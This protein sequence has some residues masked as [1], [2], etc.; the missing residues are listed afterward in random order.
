MY[1]PP[2]C[3]YFCS[4][5]AAPPDA[6]AALEQLAYEFG[7]TYDAYLAT[8]SDRRYFWSPGRRGVVGF[9][10]CRGHALATGGL[11]AP[12]EEQAEL[13]DAFLEFTRRNRL[14]ALF[15]SLGRDDLAPYRERG[16]GVNKCSEELMLRLDQTHWTGK[17]Y[18]WVR[19]QE[20][21][22]LRQD[23]ALEEVEADPHDPEY[24][25]QLAPQLAE[26]S[27]QHVAQTLHA[28]ELEFFEGRFTPLEL[29][30]RRLFVA[31]QDAR[32]VAFVVCNPALG[33]DLWAI[34]IYRR[35]PDAPRGVIPFAM[36]QIMRR[37]KAEGVSYVSLSSVPFLRCGPPFGGDSKSA[38]F[39]CGFWWKR[40]N[41]LFDVRGLYHY[42]TRFR[43]AFRELYMAGYPRLTYRSMLAITDAWGVFRVH[44][45]RLAKHAVQHW[46]QA[47]RKT[48]DEPPWRPERVIRALRSRTPQSVLAEPVSAPCGSRQDSTSEKALALR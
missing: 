14:R 24:R 41:W 9:R 45:W 21:Y 23:V 3:E 25:D 26:I 8:E 36:L 19:R 27:R 31:W 48:L 28:R 6:A 18:E 5:A 16:F 10:I 33:G 40:M 11:L 29:G 7:Q 20:N 15:C 12:P 17:P 43:P 34:E 32:P 35:R 44:P 46:R 4:R 2:G 37:L 30:R 38:Q 22:C 13:L 39:A 1:T 47:E 42:K